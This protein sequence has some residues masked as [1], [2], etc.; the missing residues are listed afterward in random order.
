MLQ[1]KRYRIDARLNSNP[2]VTLSAVVMAHD[3]D[4]ARANATALFREL[5]MEGAVGS[6]LTASVQLAVP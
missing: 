1:P 4:D 3:V 6:L 2:E 5:H